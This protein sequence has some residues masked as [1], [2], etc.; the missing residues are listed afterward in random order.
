MKFAITLETDEDGFIVISC[1]AL[2]GC[3]SQGKSKDEAV[4]NIKEAI[5]GFVISMR[6][7]G[8]PIPSIDEVQEIEV[9]V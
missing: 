5:E 4:A 7:H 9:A 1:P 2:P 6:N 8:E 3:H